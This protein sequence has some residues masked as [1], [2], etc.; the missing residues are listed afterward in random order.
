MADSLPQTDSSASA[1]DNETLPPVE[2]PSAGFIVQLFVIP[3]LI[4]LVIVLLW[5]G[6]SWLAHRGTRPEELVRQM[7][8]NRA[9]SWQLAYNFS[10]ELR[11]NDLY[12][13]DPAL[14]QEVAQFLDE[15]LDQP[16]PPPGGN[17][18]GGTNPRNQEIVRRG[19]LC[20]TLGEFLLPK[21]VLPVLIRAA[22]DHN[23]EDEIRVRL[24]ALE[25][26]ALLIES[27]SIKGDQAPPEVLGVLLA[28]S[29]DNDR[30]IASRATVGLTALRQPEA[31]ARLIAML[32][33]PHYVDV[34]Y[35]VATGLARLGQM[36]CFEMLVEMLDPEIDRGLDNEDNASERELKRLRILLN[37]LRATRMLATQNPQADL[38]QLQLAVEQLLANEENSQILVEAQKTLQRLNESAG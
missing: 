37:A 28:A 20:R 4:V 31:T 3:G 24:A 7:R 6:F 1:R 5:L 21:P 22:A 38:K 35:N 34:H 32:D 12:R 17:G 33:E 10:E 8:Q 29:E 9:N 30:K 15:L 26:M 23:D 27:T 2:Q 13:K 14:A 18:L 25:A 19:F 11:Q 36:E 16:L